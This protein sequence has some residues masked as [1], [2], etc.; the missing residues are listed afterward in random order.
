M[1]ESIFN[2]IK[3]RMYTQRDTV[4]CRKKKK[5]TLNL[6][7]M[8][9]IIRP[10]EKIKPTT[11]QNVLK[12]NSNS[13]ESQALCKRHEH[14]FTLKRPHHHHW[15]IKLVSSNSPR[16][17][18]LHR[19]NYWG[20]PVSRAVQEWC[21]ASCVRYF[22]FPDRTHTWRLLRSTPMSVTVLCC[23]WIMYVV[24]YDTPT[25]SMDCHIHL[26]GFRLGWQ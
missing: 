23:M 8:S 19:W 21:I 20:H 4:Q 22:L 15:V 13:T 9:Q 11:W 1:H 6:S 5:N 16:I 14:F 7:Q 10:A 3:R 17:S 26:L 12:H 2:I 25:L 24:D 18:L